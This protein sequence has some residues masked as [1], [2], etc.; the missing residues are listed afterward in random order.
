MVLDEDCRRRGVLRD[1]VSLVYG[2]QYYYCYVCSVRECFFCVFCDFSGV[3]GSKPYMLFVWGWCV[4][5]AVSWAKLE[6]SYFVLTF[7]FFRTI[8]T[9]QASAI[10][11]IADCCRSLICGG[12]V[13]IQSTINTLLYYTVLL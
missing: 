5:L 12:V 7:E 10:R 4:S 6:H 13:V 8:R 1:V 3:D 11:T 9:Q 2:Y